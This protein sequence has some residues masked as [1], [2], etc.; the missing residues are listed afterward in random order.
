M[1]ALTDQNEL[2][3]A[4]KRPRVQLRFN[5]R[6]SGDRIKLNI[7]CLRLCSHDCKNCELLRLCL[8]LDLYDCIDLP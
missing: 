4:P 5:A 7:E 8:I 2:I 3:Q 1:K 6:N